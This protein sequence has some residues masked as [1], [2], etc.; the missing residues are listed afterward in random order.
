MIGQEYIKELVKKGVVESEDYYA[1]VQ[2]GVYPLMDYLRPN[3][4]KQLYSWILKTYNQMEAN[5]KGSGKV[6]SEYVL[7]I[8]DYLSDISTRKGTAWTRGD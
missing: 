5:Q 2:M 3:E 7:A 4:I 8:K 1:D 6:G